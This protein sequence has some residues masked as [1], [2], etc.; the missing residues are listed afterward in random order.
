MKKIKIILLIV[1]LS[2]TMSGCLK[3]DKMED[4]NIITTSYPIEYVTNYLYG[5][6]STITSI[7]PRGAEIDKYKITKKQLKDFSSND[8]FIYNG[9]SNECDYAI[10]MLNNN[11]N[12]KIIDASFGVDTLYS[13]YDLWLN[14]SNILMI[15]QNIR[16]EL[17]E[18]ITNPYLKNEINDRYQLLKVNISELETEFK[19]TADNSQ[20]KKIISSDESLKFLEKY[21]FEVIN[22]T[23]QGKNKEN[24]ITLAKNLLENN[25][26][27]YIFV[28]ENDKNTKLVDSITKEYK[29]ETL[30]FKIIE[31]IDEEDLANN[32][33]YL[34]IMHNNIE[35]IKKET[36]K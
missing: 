7:Y 6:N 31:T 18:Y 29:K 14:P 22:L 26:L 19:K 17:S 10:S 27:N 35:Q 21:G 23:E 2:C 15:A 12:L 20:N 30:T 36:Y 33:D 32:E 34:S 13:K 28:H 8:L 1:L 4:I 9:D 25:K 5:E 11:R 24:N 16:N 3:R